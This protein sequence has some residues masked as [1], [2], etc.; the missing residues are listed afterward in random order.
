MDGES[1]S[2]K[3]VGEGKWSRSCSGNLFVF[4]VVGKKAAMDGNWLLL[5][6]RYR[7]DQRERIQPCSCEE[8]FQNAMRLLN[9][10][11]TKLNSVLHNPL[12]VINSSN[13]KFRQ[14]I[15]NLQRS[16]RNLLRETERTSTTPSHH[17]SDISRSIRSLRNDIAKIFKNLPNLVTA[18]VTPVS[19]KYFSTLATLETCKLSLLEAH[20]L[21]NVSNDDLTKMAQESRNVINEI[22]N[23]LSLI[24]RI[25][26]KY[27]N[28]KRD[29][30]K[31]NATTVRLKDSY[32]KSKES[33]GDI[34]QLVF[35]TKSRSKERRNV[36]EEI[37]E[38]LENVAFPVYNTSRKCG[39]EVPKHQNDFEE[40]LATQFK[41][42][43]DFQKLLEKMD[44]DL[45]K[46]NEEAVVAERRNRKDNEALKAIYASAI[47]LLDDADG[48]IAFDILDVTGIN[49]ENDKN[50][51]RLQEELEELFRKLEAFSAELLELERL[52]QI[53]LSFLEVGLRAF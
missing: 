31:L 13:H 30:S 20:K 3:R 35:N 51:L 14:K 4:S 23:L 42:T 37:R 46:F 41:Q 36:A 10:E 29:V 2:A 9:D 45:K 8:L 12:V 50:L 7:C 53:N 1:A 6:Y 11:V 34:K 52:S 32:L 43:S 16:I 33:V 25:S 5:F 24:A 19:E 27:E 18:D 17:F 26:N 21:S 38:L 22:A 39:I 49:D 47:R 28:A 44:E 48:R 40:R 15:K